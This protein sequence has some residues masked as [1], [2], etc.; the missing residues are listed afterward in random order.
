MVTDSFVLIRDA[1]LPAVIFTVITIFYLLIKFGSWLADSFH[2]ISNKTQRSQVMTTTNRDQDTQRT[3][4]RNQ[5]DTEGQSTDSG[6]QAISADNGLR[7]RTTQTGPK[8]KYIQRHTT[9]STVYYHLKSLT[10]HHR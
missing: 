3:A 4:K 9:H 5:S 6:H 8:A 10:S 7:V 1:G 2:A